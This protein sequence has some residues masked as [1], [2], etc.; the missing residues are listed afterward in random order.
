MIFDKIENIK[1]YKGIYEHLDEAIE[2]IE[3]HD[4]STLEMGKT[5]IDDNLYVNIV[6]GT[7]IS[8]EK[9][10]YEYHKQ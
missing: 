9:G 10:V 4:L 6:N 5:V 7:L 3:N 8:E 1:I 2:Y